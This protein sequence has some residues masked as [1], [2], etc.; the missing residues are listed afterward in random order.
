[1]IAEKYTT[2]EHAEYIDEAIMNLISNSILKREEKFRGKFWKAMELARK[3]KFPPP[4]YPE[5]PKTPE[6][7]IYQTRHEKR[8]RYLAYYGKLF[9]NEWE[10]LLAKDEKFSNIIQNLLERNADKIEGRHKL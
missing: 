8:N 5:K 4:S 2:G 9:Q 10:E 6:G 7:E 3:L 1:M